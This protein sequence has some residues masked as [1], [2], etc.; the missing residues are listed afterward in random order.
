MRCGAFLNLFAYDRTVCYNENQ[1]NI[2]DD[3][4]GG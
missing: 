2:F 4:K 3:V 1:I